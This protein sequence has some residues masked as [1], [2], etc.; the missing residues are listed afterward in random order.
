MTCPAYFAGL[1]PA[2]WLSSFDNLV[3][4]LVVILELELLI[5]QQHLW[6]YTANTVLDLL[7]GQI[8]LTRFEMGDEHLCIALELAQF[9]REQTGAQMLGEHRQLLLTA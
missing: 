2:T 8:Q 3:E 9:I 6:P 7:H 4:W 1:Y 5:V